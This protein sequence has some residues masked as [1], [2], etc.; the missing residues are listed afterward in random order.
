MRILGLNI[1]HSIFFKEDIL[2][3]ISTVL[4]VEP[5]TPLKGIPEKSQVSV[6]K[7]RLLPL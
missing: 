1:L 6:E 2:N 7:S 5:K 4:T 3:I